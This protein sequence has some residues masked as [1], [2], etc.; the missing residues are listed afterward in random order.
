MDIRPVEH[1]DRTQVK[2]YESETL[3]VVDQKVKGTLMKTAQKLSFTLRGR[4]TTYFFSRYYMLDLSTGQLQIKRSAVGKPDT[5]VELF[6]DGNRVIHVD[7]NLSKNLVINYEGFFKTAL[8]AKIEVA[9]DFAHPFTVRLQKNRVMLLWA[10]NASEKSMWVQ[11]FRDLQMQKDDQD[12]E[13]KEG[14]KVPSMQLQ[15][16]NEFVITLIKCL[17]PIRDKA[18]KAIAQNVDFRIRI[19]Q[20]GV[21]YKTSQQIKA[22]QDKYFFMRLFELNVSTQTLKVF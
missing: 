21:L 11:A 3:V 19:H 22:Y 9:D 5:T 16:D 2:R 12:E 14:E 18:G 7:E 8:K 20:K 13:G 1:N 10:A 6:E 17:V 4:Q 15:D